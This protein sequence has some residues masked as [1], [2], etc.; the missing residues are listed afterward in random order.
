MD[1]VANAIRGINHELRSPLGSAFVGLAVLEEQLDPDT[2]SRLREVID[3]LRYSLQSSIAVLDDIV[4]QHKIERGTLSLN[5]DKHDLRP[6][7]AQVVDQ[8]RVEALLQSVSLILENEGEEQVHAQV[9]AALIQQVTRNVLLK[10]LRGTEKQGVVTA[11]LTSQSTTVRIEV[12]VDH[13]VS[14]HKK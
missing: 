1:P 8:L 3:L 6:L 2:A 14:F 5:R 7:L 11:R 4:L 12:A 9:D 10:A 13:L